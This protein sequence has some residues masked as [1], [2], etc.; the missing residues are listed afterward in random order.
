[1]PDRNQPIIHE[2]MSVINGSRELEQRLLQ[3]FKDRLILDAGNTQQVAKYAKKL[4]L[5]ISEQECSQ[6][7]DSIAQRHLVSI[8]IEHVDEVVNDLFPNRFIEP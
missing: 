3:H 2:I 6:V 5:Q 7:L 1:M 4:R 8:D